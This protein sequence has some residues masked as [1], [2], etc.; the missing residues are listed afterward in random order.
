MVLKISVC[1]RS[2]HFTSKDNEEYSF[3]TFQVHS[4][5]PRDPR[6]RPAYSEP[7]L[8]YD[9][10]PDRYEQEYAPR[11]RYDDDDFRNG[12]QGFNEDTIDRQ[13]PYKPPGNVVK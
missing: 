4:E 5:P 7:Q 1:W 13:R 9:E 11:A 3:C 10:G 6:V 2:I 8:R 12:R